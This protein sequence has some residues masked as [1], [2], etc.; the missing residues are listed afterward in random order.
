MNTIR[1]NR[2]ELNR[3]LEL[4]NLFNDTG[5][6]GYVELTQ[7]SDSGIGSV[8]TAKF[9]IEHKEVEGEFTVIITDVEHW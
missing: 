6:Y 4:L 3:V 9:N 5:D 8:L 1:L 2:R 7:E